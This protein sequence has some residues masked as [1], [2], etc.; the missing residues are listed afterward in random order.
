MGGDVDDQVE[1]RTAIVT[2]E[3]APVGALRRWGACL[4]DGPPCEDSHMCMIEAR[5]GKPA[6]AS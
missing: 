4:S 6:E 1:R 3:T 5:A 2:T